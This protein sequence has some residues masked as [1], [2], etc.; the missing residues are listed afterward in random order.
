MA[1][2]MFRG[3]RKMGRGYYY[4]IRT[5]RNGERLI[6]LGTDPD[7]A[8]TKAADIRRRLKAGKPPEEPPE[9]PALTV[10]AV[11]RQWL[12]EGA[13]HTRSERF[14]QETE[15]RIN[16][17]LVPFMG[18]ERIEDVTARTL[19]A[20]RNWMAERKRGE[21]K[22]PLAAATVRHAL[23]EARAV[24]NYALTIGAIDRSPIPGGWMPTIPER[25]PEPLTADECKKLRKMPEPH[26]RVIRFML[27]TGLRWGEMT[28]AQ[29]KDIRDGVLI[30]RISKSGKVRRVPVPQDVLAECKGRV[31]RLCPLSDSISFN[32]R[33]RELSGVERFHSHLARHTFATDW[34]SAGGSLAGLKAVLGH[35]SVAVTEQYGRIEDDLVLREARRLE[36]RRRVARS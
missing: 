3:I 26:G 32:R 33:V 19:F 10:E 20:Y 23:G 27:A 2:T 30:V 12:A 9:R 11:A 13:K 8:A 5:G 34:L 6:P 31:G 21:S 15:S 1:R 24:V 17:F 4:R 7:T 22:Q 18:R 14:L 35:S 28:R 29:A 36:G 16:R 25:A